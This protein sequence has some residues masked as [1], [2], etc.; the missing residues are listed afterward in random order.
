MAPTPAR[1][2]DAST[3]RLVTY[4]TSLVSF[5]SIG[6]RE[7]S[8]RR[9]TTPTTRGGSDGEG[10]GHSAT[11]ASCSGA[12]PGVSS[13]LVASREYVARLCV[14]TAPSAASESMCVICATSRVSARLIVTVGLVSDAAGTASTACVATTTRIPRTWRP[15]TRLSRADAAGTSALTAAV[16]SRAP[17]CGRNRTLFA[18]RFGDVDHG[19]VLYFHYI[20]RR[21]GYALTFGAPSYPCTPRSSAPPSTCGT[22]P[23]PAHA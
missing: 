3:A 10:K 2:A 11:S 17:S 4:A 13:T 23:T 14:L 9:P 16:M 7:S 12:A 18:R 15:P 19:R 8:R 5:I 22:V 20:P 6:L 21:Y 1:L